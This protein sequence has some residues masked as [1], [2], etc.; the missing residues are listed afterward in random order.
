MRAEDLAYLQAESPRTLS[1]WKAQARQ[2]SLLLVAARTEGVASYNLNS[3]IERTCSDLYNEIQLCTEAT[4]RVAETSQA[5][6]AE[7]TPV[8]D[9]VRLVLLEITELSTHSTPFTLEE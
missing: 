7:L 5:A 8:E 3:M 6:A 2:L 4:K 9:A 1:G